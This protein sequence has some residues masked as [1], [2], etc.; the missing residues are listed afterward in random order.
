MTKWLRGLMR[1]LRY[2]KRAH[3]LHYVRLAVLREAWPR[4]VPGSLV[5]PFGRLDYADIASL[6]AQYLSIFVNREYDFECKTKRPVILDCGGNIGLSALWFKTRYPE[7][8]LTVFEP[9][10]D[11]VPM[12]R[13]NLARSGFEDVNVVQAAAWSS[14]TT[15]YIQN[16]RADGGFVGEA[17]SDGSRPIP[18]VR[19]ADYV[20]G[21][22]DL[23]K[24]DIEG[25]EFEVINDLAQTGKLSNIFAI[26]GELHAKP[27]HAGKVGRLLTTLH[28]H[29]FKVTISSACP[30]PEL[31]SHAET[32]PF[33][34]LCDGKYL[35]LFFAW[36]KEAR[37]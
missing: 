6:E 21:P 33:P 36:R 34:A 10:P 30:A 24:L 7:A 12:L 15:L 28:E 26:A 11:L 9:G 20:N 19:L 27:S 8:R 18:A 32:T 14:E 29:G 35:A 4:F 17:Q 13:A 16:D 2:W 1:I 37:S 22:V 23:L 31:F 3:D 25:A 5:L